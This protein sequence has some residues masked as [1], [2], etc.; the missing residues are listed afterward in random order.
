ML[1]TPTLVLNSSPWLGSSIRLGVLGCCCI[2]LGFAGTAWSSIVFS[3]AQDIP[4]PQDFDGVY[5]NV[6]LSN[7]DPVVSASGDWDVNPFFGGIGIANSPGFQPARS[8]IGNEDT[9]VRISATSVIDGSL[10]FSS[11]WGGSG[12]EDAS[13]HIGPAAA[14]FEDGKPGY[15][16]FQ[17]DT[18]GDVLLY[19]WMRIVLTANSSN[20]VIHSWAY[21][22]SGGAI[23]AGATGQSG[24]QI[25]TGVTAPISASDAGDSILLAS[26]GKLSFDDGVTGG[27][28]TGTIDGVGQ[29]DIGGSG[30]L[31]LGGNNAFTGTAS[32]QESSK[33]IVGNSSNIGSAT[34]VLGSSAALVFDST[35]NNDG[36]ANTFS[37]S[38][39]LD[40][41]GGILENS[42]SGSVVLGGAVT[43]AGA[44][45]K[46]GSG[47]LTLSGTNTYTG[48]T[49]VAGGLL[50]VNGDIS[51]SS[52]T[53]VVSGGTLGGSGTVGALI[54]EDGASIAPGNSPGSLTVNG[55]VTWLAGGNYNWQLVDALETAGT[56]WDAIAITGVLDLSA[57]SAENPFNLNLWSLSSNT[58]FDGDALNFDPSRAYSWT[59]ATADGGISGFEASLFSIHSGANNGTSGFSNA[60]NDGT[61]S[62]AVE[63]NHLNLVF[64]AVPEPEA[65]LATAS[66]LA[67]GLLMRRRLA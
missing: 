40:G 35:V 39:T 9:I 41:S 64:T 38:I 12:A 14:Q 36:V 59:I 50:T 46:T 28:F 32:V 21:D 61:F 19:G 66:L 6:N 22:N 31:R 13:G 34:V 42:G 37:N 58:A 3:G 20:G 26:G 25:V 44:L 54:L 24:Q 45:T 57:L 27:V 16:G 52:I 49:T 65:M 63:G 33:L 67:A 7:P 62:L 17:L 23:L 55:N 8:G 2:L 4:I 5:I 18:G 15:L 30:G 47:N 11:D 1:K 43:G 56:G 29:L 60:L 53:T 51:S 10:A 48:A